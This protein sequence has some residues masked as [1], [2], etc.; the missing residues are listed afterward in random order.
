MF[1][2]PIIYLTSFLVSISQLIKN[3]LEGITI[4]MV[5]G[6][7]I[8]T[9]ALSLLY[10]YG[11]GHYITFLQALK[12]ILVLIALGLLIYHYSRKIVLHIVDKLMIAFFLYTLAYVFLPIGQYGIIAKLFA[13]KSISFF[14]LLYFTGRLFDPAK[15]YINRFFY[16]I[17]LVSIAASLVQFYEVYHYQHFQTMTGYADYNYYIFN[18]EPSGNYGLSWTFEIDTGGKRFASFFANPLENSSATLLTVSVLA[19]LYTY[20]DNRINLNSFGWLTFASTLTVI[21]FSLSRASFFSYFLMIYIYSFL[22]NKKYILWTIHIFFIGAV[23]YFLFLISK[24]MEDFITNTINFSNA[25][26]LGHLIE[27]LDGIQAMINSP[28]GVG[29]GE[30]G[31]ISVALGQNIGGENQFII[32]GVQAG[33]IGLGIY[34]AIYWLMI[35]NAY[36][37][38]LRFKGKEKKVSLSVLLMKIGFIV[39]MLTANFE[40]YIYASYISWFLSGLLISM[41]VQQSEKNTVDQSAM[42]NLSSQ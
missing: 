13:F 28:L 34:I 30:S 32:I 7:P 3:K 17:C 37:W 19:G 14:V 5:F 35:K 33:V 22:T 42:V 9:T 21:F 16:Y 25:S 10:M 1:V 11:F 27:W 39:P 2:F 15:I 40:S 41:I 38:F 31:K 29:L 12:E 20:N 18:Q 26:S 8:Y 24:D 6:L 4:F 23:L 36:R